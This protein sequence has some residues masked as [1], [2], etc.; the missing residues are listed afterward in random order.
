MSFLHVKKHE[1]EER[2]EKYKQ[3][4]VKESPESSNH[5][6]NVEQEENIFSQNNLQNMGGECEKFDLNR[7]SAF[8]NNQEENFNDFMF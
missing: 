8:S 2:L 3:V 6:Q 5:D 7:G 4:K 1:L